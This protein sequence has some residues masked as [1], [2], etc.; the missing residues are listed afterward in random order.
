[1]RLLDHQ[2]LMGYVDI[3]SIVEEIDQN[4]KVLGQD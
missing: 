1:M 3:H 2:M 4:N